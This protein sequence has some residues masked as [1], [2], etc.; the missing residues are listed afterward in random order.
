MK[1]KNYQEAVEIILNDRKFKKNSSPDLT[2]KEKYFLK[3][4]T[5]ISYN[6]HHAAINKLNSLKED[7]DYFLAQKFYLLSECYFSINEYE[8]SLCSNLEALHYFEKLND[9]TYIF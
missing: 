9:S 8:K 3:I 6:Q 4:R 1:K 2:S 7:N 5:L